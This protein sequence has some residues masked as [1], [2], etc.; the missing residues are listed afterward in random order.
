MI[1]IGNGRV[2]TRDE[3][4]PYIENGAVLIDGKVIKEIGKTDEL[5]AKYPDAQYKDAKGRLVMPGFIN[6]HMHYYSTFARGMF[7]DNPPATM[8]SDILK[9]L[10]WRLDRAL[11]LEDVYY[12]AAMPMIEQI[13]SGVTTVIDHHASAYAVEGSLFKIADAA[14][15]FGIRSNLCYETSDR[16]GEAIAKAGIKENADFIKYC[17]EQKDD[18]IKGLFGFHAS[19]TVSDK[20]LDESLAAAASVNGGFHVHCAEGIE[21]VAD[22]LAKYN[23]R[24]IERWYKRGVLNEKSIAVHCIHLSSDEIDM[25]KESNVAVVHNPESNMGNAVGIAP[26]LE[27]M[28]RGV[29][30]GLGTDGYT[31]DMTESYK[32]AN[33]IHKHVNKL[34][35]VGW[36]EP[37]Q[38]LFDNNRKIVNRFIDG[39]TGILKEGAYADIIIVDYKGPTPVNE[40]NLNS[41]I[42]FGV[43]GRNVDTTI[44]NGRVVMDERKLVDIDEDRVAAKSVELAQK[45]WNRI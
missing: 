41:H 30:V 7:L 22:S 33:I 26:I 34:P 5:K 11:T 9:G 14:R 42:L 43:T 29:L 35:S 37:P 39:T 31:A 13:K 36:T 45:L 8:F 23:Q 16:D 38:M 32:V 27:M 10:W 3:N 6:P 4:N 40:T 25:L 15:E 28:K 21:D 18:M 19:M 2:F 20:T 24:V 1:L 12:S 17:N 44:I